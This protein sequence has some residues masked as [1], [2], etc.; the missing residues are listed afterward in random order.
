MKRP[1]LVPL[2]CAS[3]LG[4]FACG[5]SAPELP[6][7]NQ[8][9]APGEA[10]RTVV[11]APGDNA[12][13]LRYAAKAGVT[14]QVDM[15][16]DMAIEGGGV[17]MSFKMQLGGALAIDAV[18]EQG[19]FT[20]T[21]TI[22]DANVALGGAMAA[23]GADTSMFS[24]MMKGM[25]MSFKMDAQGRMLEADLGGKDNPMMGQMQAGMDQAMQGGVV[26]FPTEAVGVGA[27]WEALAT[28]DMMG[29][30]VRVVTSYKLIA[31]D[32]DKGTLELALK[33]SADAQKMQM[34]GVPGDVDLKSMNIDAEGRVTFDLARPTAGAVDMKMNLKMDLSVQGQSA[35]MKMG[36]VIAMKT[37]G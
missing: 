36:M 15:N 34:A 33:G 13:V 30:K 28:L 20:Q 37:K 32:G 7:A 23:A 4:L 27:Q 21:M 1:I 8:F 18:D 35:T 17:D 25:K 26:P 2:L 22:T 9:P 29:A 12:R 11:K 24:D 3:L 19:A 6:P 14:D 16:L 5:K 31:L 10:A